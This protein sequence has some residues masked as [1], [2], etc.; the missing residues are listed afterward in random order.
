MQHVWAGSGEAKLWL[1]PQIRFAA[2]DG[3]DASTLRDL[4]AVVQTHRELIERGWNVC[5]GESGT[6]RRRLHVGASA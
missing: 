2:S 4:V 6:F 5:F 1:Q 3:F